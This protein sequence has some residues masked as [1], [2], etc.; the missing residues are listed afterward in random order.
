MSK[1]SEIYEKQMSAFDSL[2]AFV[3]SRIVYKEKFIDII[4]KYGTR[5]KRLLE[6][7]CGSGITSIFLGKFGYEVIGIDSDPDMV[8]LATSIAVQQ[9]S[10]VLFKVD[11]IKTLETIQGHFD[12]VFSNGVM[13][14]FSDNDIV[15][16][17]DR[18]LSVSDYV[19]IS[20]P[21]DFFTDD[22]RM[23]GD[24]RFMSVDQWHTI[25]SKVNGSV[26]EEFT[27]NPDKTTQGGPQFIGFV[28]SS[29]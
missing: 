6:A 9:E 27:F 15:T 18:H 21:S 8:K 10:A 16:I 25:L 5:T 2:D 24:E 29:L 13:E 23:Y 7:G 12:V 26:V 20:V 4:K 28:L 14:H 11:D 1:W 3:E 19:V 17:L 22:Q